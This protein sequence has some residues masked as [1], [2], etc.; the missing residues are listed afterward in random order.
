MILRDNSTSFGEIKRIFSVGMEYRTKFGSITTLQSQ[1]GSNG[2]LPVE[3]AQSGRKR[4]SHLIRL[5][6]SQF[7]MCLQFLFNH[8]EEDRILNID[9]QGAQRVHFMVKIAKRM[10]QYE[11]KVLFH[12]DNAPCHWS[13]ITVVKIH[14]LH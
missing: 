4:N 6:R 5:W 12:Q 1:I 10:V 7:G 13:M 8:L 14:E 11:E 3:L 2:W 9:H